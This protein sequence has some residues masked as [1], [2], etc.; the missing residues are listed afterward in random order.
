MKHLFEQNETDKY[1]A[2]RKK[3]VTT[4]VVLC[5]ALIVPTVLAVVLWRALGRAAAQIV[6]T[7]CTAALGCACVYLA[8]VIALDGK[9]FKF[10]QQMTVKQPKEVRISSLNV[11][12]NTTTNNGLTFRQVTANTDDGERLLYLYPGKE[13]DE[14][15]TKLYVVDKYICGYEVEHE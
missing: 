3:H 4:L 9:Q 12:K 11:D 13:V 2:L 8:Q 5:V 15:A 6:A 7:V 10:V 14:A 1:A